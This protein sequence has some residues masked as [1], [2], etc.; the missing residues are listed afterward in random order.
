MLSGWS[1][2]LLA[3]PVIDHVDASLLQVRECKFFSDGATTATQQR[4]RLHPVLTA[5]AVEPSGRFETMRTLAPPAGRGFEY[6]TG[7]GW[8]FDA[9]LAR[10][11]DLLAEKLAAPAVQAG[12]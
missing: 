12:R 3:S 1:A 11:P 5:V 2:R 7:T 8:D 9:E 4:V 10:L 6:L